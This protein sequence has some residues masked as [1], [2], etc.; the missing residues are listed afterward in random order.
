[1]MPRTGMN[2]EGKSSGQPANNDVCDCGKTSRKLLALFSI[3]LFM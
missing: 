1:M 2:E 3:V